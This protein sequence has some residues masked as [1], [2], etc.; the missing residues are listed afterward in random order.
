MK[1]LYQ[2]IRTRIE[3]ECPSIKWVRLFNNQFDMSNNDDTEKNIESPFPYPCAFI[4]FMGDNPASSGG[5]GAKRLDVQVRILIGFESYIL[6]DL[7]VF[8]VAEELQVALENYKTDGMTGLIYKGQNMDYNHDNVYVYS[9][10]FS[11]QYSD[12]VAYVKRN[13]ISAPSPLTLELTATLDID[14]ILIHTG[15][16]L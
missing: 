7:V 15:D 9:I 16:G 6:E 12:E 10:D 11:T 4:Q 13:D 14:N 5:F 1:T 3:A 8:D 2:N